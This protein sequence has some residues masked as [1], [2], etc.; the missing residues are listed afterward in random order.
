[1][2]SPPRMAHIY[3]ERRTVGDDVAGGM[4]EAAVTDGAWVHPRLRHLKAAILNV[5]AGRQSR[6]GA[7]AG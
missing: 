2:P 5:L 1:M 7:P 4:G 3:F 6:I